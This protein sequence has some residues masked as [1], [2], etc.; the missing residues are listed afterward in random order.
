MTAYGAGSEIT[1]LCGLGNPGQEYAATRHN[2][3]FQVVDRL[4][5]AYGIVLQ[6]RKFK[7]SWGTGVVA[8]RKIFIVKPLTYMN[9]SGEVVVDILK[10]FGI[11]AGQML[12]IHDDLDLPIGRIRLVPKGGA[13]GHRGVSSIMEHLGQQDF[14]RLKLGIGRPAHGE[15]VESFVLRPPY[16]EDT[17]AFNEMVERGFEAVHTVLS[18]G[19][20]AAMN[21]FNRQEQQ[22]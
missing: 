9:R 10:Y 21:R 6:Q 17:L 12:V 14:P 5:Q 20:V 11:T 22:E 13:G 15:T 18:T 4:A 19:L 1:A 16:P 7:A 2:V 8:G 3:G